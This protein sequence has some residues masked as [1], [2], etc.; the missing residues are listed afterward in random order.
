MPSSISQQSLIDRAWTLP[1]PLPAGDTDAKDKN[2]DDGVKTAEM[3]TSLKD[4][5]GITNMP[6]VGVLKVSGTG[7]AIAMRAPLA[8]LRHTCLR[9]QP[10]TFV[11]HLHAAGCTC[12]FCNAACEVHHALALCWGCSWRWAVSCVR[13]AVLF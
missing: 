12:E 2:I 13:L 9:L 3:Q 8:K 6:P 11:Q 5:D 10:H 7:C 4:V 1:A